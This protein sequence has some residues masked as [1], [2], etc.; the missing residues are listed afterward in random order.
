MEITVLLFIIFMIAICKRLSDLTMEMG[1][2][3]KE[4]T[5]SGFDNVQKDKDIILTFNGEKQTFQDR[6]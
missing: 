6:I 4:L 1:N 5:S 2:L 3:K